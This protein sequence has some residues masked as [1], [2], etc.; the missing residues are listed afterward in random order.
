MKA[1]K[2]AGR[3]P[4]DHQLVALA[5]Q[6]SKPDLC[7]LVDLASEQFGDLQRVFRL[8]MEVGEYTVAVNTGD[9][10]LQ[11]PPKLD[12]IVAAAKSLP[13]TLLGRLPVVK[14]LLAA[15]SR[16]RARGA[17]KI[18]TSALTRQAQRYREYGANADVFVVGK[19]VPVLDNAIEENLQEVLSSKPKPTN[20]AQPPVDPKPCWVKVRSGAWVGEL[21]IGDRVV[22]K[23]SAKAVNVIPV[24]DVFQK[25]GWPGAIDDPSSQDNWQRRHETIRSLNRGLKVIRF[26]GDGTNKR[27]KWTRLR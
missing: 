21:R 7:T 14:K 12:G 4:W 27:I 11:S 2:V 10:L 8:G 24:L 5:A 18:L 13:R 3:A 23:V 20:A 22:R 16:P 15:A 19:L 17:R 1:N 9:P 26:H 6:E 25:K